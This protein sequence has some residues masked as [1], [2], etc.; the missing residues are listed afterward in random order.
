M[1]AAT[2]VVLVV[3]LVAI[4]GTDARL[5]GSTKQNEKRGRDAALAVRSRFLDMA[6]NPMATEVESTMTAASAGIPFDIA[7]TARPYAS[8]MVF[9]APG[10]SMDSLQ[11]VSVMQTNKC[12]LVGDGDDDVSTSNKAEYQWSTISTGNDTATMYVSS[13]RGHCQS[14]DMTYIGY[15]SYTFP[16]SCFLYGNMYAMV[17]VTDSL[18]VFPA[19]SALV[20]K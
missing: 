2:I 13:V 5:A 7:S 1:I 20:I 4:S 19:V 18:P 10:C 8:F 15:T 9:A 11:T 17:S 16:T 14:A 12:I 6:R 3:V